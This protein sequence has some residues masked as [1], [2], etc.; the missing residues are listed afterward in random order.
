MNNQLVQ[1]HTSFPI[2][3]FLGIHKT[4]SKNNLAKEMV[5]A[6]VKLSLFSIN[7]QAK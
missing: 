2:T 1:L 7:M 3:K 5:F 4:L 6:I